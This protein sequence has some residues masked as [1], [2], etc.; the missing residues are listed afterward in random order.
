ME[1]NYCG[2][3]FHHLVAVYMPTT[4]CSTFG[5]V[6]PKKNITEYFGG[7]K[8]LLTSY[9][10]ALCRSDQNIEIQNSILLLCIE[11]EII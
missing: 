9:T 2:D 5:N 10:N 11:M 7:K 1:L 6:S 3:G 8:R 4:F